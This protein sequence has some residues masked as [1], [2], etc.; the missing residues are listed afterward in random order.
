MVDLTLCHLPGVEIP[1]GLV[2]SLTVTVIVPCLGEFL[3]GEAVVD[4]SLVD[5]GSLVGEGEWAETGEAPRSDAGGSG[6]PDEGSRASMSTAGGERLSRRARTRSDDI[7]ER[8]RA[9][10]R[11]MMELA[12][13]ALG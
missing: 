13:Q 8:E 7:H 3:V 11:A 10:L 9:M 2:D 4:S 6:W 5:V 12:S 1:L